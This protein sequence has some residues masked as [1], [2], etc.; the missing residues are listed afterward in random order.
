[1]KLKVLR[2]IETGDPLRIENASVVVPSTIWFVFDGA[3][4]FR[5]LDSAGVPMEVLIHD[6]AAMQCVWDWGSFI[7]AALRAGWSGDKLKRT[8]RD[9]WYR[10]G[11]DTKAPPSQRGGLRGIRFETNWFP[12]ID[13]LVEEFQLAPL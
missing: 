12:L 4:V 2:I 3:D 13:A 8:I 9:G 11:V 6:A 10:L 1:M 5:Y 7:V